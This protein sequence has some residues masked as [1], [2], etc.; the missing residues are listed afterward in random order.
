MKKK[1]ICLAD[2]LLWMVLLCGGL[3]SACRSEKEDPMEKEP[4]VPATPYITKVLEFVPCPGQFVN[5]LPEFKEGDT[6]ETMNQKVLELI[7]HNKR[8]LVSLGGF[9]GYV[10][11][12][13]DHTI[14]NKPGS[15][16]FRVLGNAFNGNSSA[17]TSGTA[18]G[19]SYEPGVILVA[20]DKN[21]NGKPDADEWYEI[22]GSAQKGEVE[23]WYAEAKA[24]GNDLHCY[25]DYEITYYKPKAEPKT[26]EEEAQYIRWTDNKGGE[27]YLPK[28]EYHRQPYFPQ[29]IQS[30]KLTFK[31][32]RLPQNGLNHG[33]EEAPYFVLFSFAYGY[34][35]NAVN[36][37]EG[38]CIDIDWAVDAHGKAVHLPGVD[39]VKIYTGVH[40][41][42]GWLG[43]CSTEVMGVEDLHLLKN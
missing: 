32:T 37:T 25:S 42:N 6:Q 1:N 24:V 3:L 13:F 36:D 26:Q 21:G 10:V 19:G 23:P 28:N 39:F 22:Q 2:R 34:A 35:D 11:V 43:E 17:A 41:V 33:T 8:G 5:V 9:G 16:D 4:E 18:Q 31:G 20:Y 12:G 14:E 15:R 38:A 7:G 30:D 40:Q 27:G 29:W